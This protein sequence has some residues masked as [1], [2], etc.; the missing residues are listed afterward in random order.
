VLL[1]KLKALTILTSIIKLGKIKDLILFY[2]MAHGSSA[3]GFV[4]LRL[5]DVIQQFES[6]CRVG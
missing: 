6:V 2:P 3:L 1:F 5:R 4:D